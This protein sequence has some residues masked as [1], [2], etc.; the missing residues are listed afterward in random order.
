MW[1][2]PEI[3]TTKGARLVHTLSFITLDDDD[4]FV[5][6][7]YGKDTVRFKIVFVNSPPTGKNSPAQEVI[8]RAAHD[9][10]GDLGIITFKN[11]ITKFEPLCAFKM[12]GNEETE[13]NLFM[14]CSVACSPRH[15]EY[16]EMPQ[17]PVPI[18]RT[19]AMSFWSQPNKETQYGGI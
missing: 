18:H 15:K 19:I 10:D 12:Y 7:P 3:T 1:D 16:L 13:E 11:I 9:S 8:I 4:I 2:E 14:T 17:K 5:K 6:F